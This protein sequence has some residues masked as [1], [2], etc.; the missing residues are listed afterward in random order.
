MGSPRCLVL[1]GSGH[2]GSEVCRALAAGGAEVAFSYFNGEARAKE[3]ERALPGAKA[4]RAD[5][6]D[7]AEAARVVDEAAGLLGG[8]DALVQCAGTAG[9]P[10]LYRGRAADGC[11]KFLSVD[12]DG[13]DEMQDLTVKSTFSAAQAA[14]KLMRGQGGGQIV[15]VGSMDGVKPVPAPVH[16][17]AAKGALRAMVSALAKELGR[18]GIKVNLIAPGILSG[19]VGGLLSPDLL[20]DYTT[21]SALKRVGTAAEVAQAVAW[22]VLQNTYVTG[23][24]VL[25]DGGL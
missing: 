4:L 8:L 13:Y 20:S 15:V 14:A 23:Q 2:V 9:D 24:S 19:G 6:R 18:R 17:A 1:G 22:F 12:E 7:F 3:L 25:L 16:Y 5:L 11:D 10:E 21:H